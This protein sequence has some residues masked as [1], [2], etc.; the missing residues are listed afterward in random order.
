MPVTRSIIQPLCLS[1]CNAH[2]PT[3]SLATADFNRPLR[4]AF[5]SVYVYAFIEPIYCIRLPF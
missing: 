4:H 3:K 1:S 5:D 2:V